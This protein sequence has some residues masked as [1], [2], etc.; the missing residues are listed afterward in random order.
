MN[1]ESNQ[2][3]RKVLGKG[4]SALLP[5]KGGAARQEAPAAPPASPGAAPGKKAE[6]PENFESFQSIPLSAISPNESQPRTSWD[7]ERMEELAQSIR[8]NGL[9]QPITVT[10]MAPGKY[11][12]VAGERRWRAARMAGLTEIPAM[13]RT[14]EKWVGGTR[15]GSGPSWRWDNVSRDVVRE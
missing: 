10:Q 3:Q 13:V 2:S 5:P 14:V 15:I 9:I 6:L 8:A 7:L 11:S 4:L 12:I 1:K